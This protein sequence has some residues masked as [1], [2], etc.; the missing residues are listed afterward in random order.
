MPVASDVVFGSAGPTLAFRRRSTPYCE[1]T[2]KSL[3]LSSVQPLV[4]AF[5]LRS[6]QFLTLFMLAMLSKPAPDRPFRNHVLVVV[7]CHADDFSIFAGGSIQKLI[8]E[9]YTGFL[10][11]VTD[12][13]KSGGPDPQLNSSQNDREVREVAQLLGLRAVYSLNFKNDE[14]GRV[15]HDRLRDTI[16]YYLRKLKADTVYTFDPYATY[17]EEN[18]DHLIVARAVEDAAINAANARY[19]PE[20]IGSSVKPQ[21]VTDAYYWSRAPFP[22]NTVTDISKYLDRKMDAL[23]HHHAQFPESMVQYFRA[24]DERIGHIFGVKAAEVSH[25]I[26][27]HNTQTC[28]TTSFTLPFDLGS[29]TLLP[30][31]RLNNFKGKIIAVISPHGIDFVEAAGG[32]ITQLIRG[33]AHVYLVR[34]TDDELHGGTLPYTEARVKMEQATRRAAETLGIHYV[35][36]LDLKDGEVAEVAEPELRA[37]FAAIFRSIAPDV[38]FTVDPWA[39]YDPDAD[40]ARIG[41]AVED[42]AWSASHVSFYP[43]LVLAPRTNFRVIINR[44]FWKSNYAEQAPNYRVD[45]HSSLE[46][47]MHALQAFADAGLSM[48]RERLASSESFYYYHAENPLDWFADWLANSRSLQASTKRPKFT[49]DTKTCK[50][51]LIITSE[52]TNWI[53]HAAATVLDMIRNGCEVTLVSVGDGSKGNISPLSIQNVLISFGI[54]RVID[55]GFREGE[56]GSVPPLILRHRL[57]EL[58]K[59]W[60]PDMILLPDPWQPYI[61]YEDR[62][63]GQIGSEAVYILSLK[64]MTAH[65]L[66]WEQNGALGNAEFSQ[67]MELKNSLLKRLHFPSIWHSEQ[68]RTSSFSS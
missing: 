68:F 32:T 10:V 6:L 64:G 44:Y 63:V 48:K 21:I 20:Q 66:Y 5:W 15:P 18:P 30:S 62:V 22:V 24:H 43:E 47:K 60:M 37:R 28:S 13:E 57:M 33:G 41:H 59:E 52:P 36:D 53:A 55:L 23:K 49:V 38:I 9:G 11:R 45:I 27:Y 35:I 42:A 26:C 54:S 19:A 29:E 16:M 17:G 1:I 2:E 61:S 46:T 40:N 39:L 12:D 34:V 58:L 50:K 56:L 25:H 51:V 3:V 31:A 7:T 67:N 8:D 14:L 65:I 4:A